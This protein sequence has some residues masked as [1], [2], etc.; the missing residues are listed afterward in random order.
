MIMPLGASQQVRQASRL[1]KRTEVPATG[2]A[3][4]ATPAGICIDD[5]LGTPVLRRSLAKG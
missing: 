1:G 2:D 5:A 3:S 4:Q